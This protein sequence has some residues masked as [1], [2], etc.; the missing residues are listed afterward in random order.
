M[1]VHNCGSITDRAMTEVTL[2]CDMSDKFIT[3]DVL[4]D[5]QSNEDRQVGR[6]GLGSFHRRVNR[7]KVCVCVNISLIVS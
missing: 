2:C 5:V 7:M 3:V 4:C 6:H 1:I